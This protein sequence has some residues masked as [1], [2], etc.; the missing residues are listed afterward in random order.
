MQ[1]RA[2]ILA[3]QVTGNT[4]VRGL[5]PVN[6]SPYGRSAS[7]SES[8]S[9]AGRV[10]RG[11]RLHTHRGRPQSHLRDGTSTPRSYAICVDTHDGDGAPK[12]SRAFKCILQAE[13]YRRGNVGR[14]REEVTSHCQVSSG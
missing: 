11:A 14:R 4:G 12:G 8:G 13:I 5:R 2:T 3:I 7:L 9:A 1:N 6:A 10:R